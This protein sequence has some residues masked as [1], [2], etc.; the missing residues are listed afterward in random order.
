MVKSIICMSLIFILQKC[1][2]FL[3]LTQICQVLAAEKKRGLVEQISLSYL[4]FPVINPQC[5]VTVLH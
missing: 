2:T 1:K 4:S 3:T 5:F